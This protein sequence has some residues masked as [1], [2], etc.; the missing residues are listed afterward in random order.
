MIVYTI[1]FHA[2]GITRPYFFSCTVTR[3]MNAFAVTP[4]ST[5]NQ[6]RTYNLL[7]VRN[8]KRKEGVGGLPLVTSALS[9]SQVYRTLPFPSSTSITFFTFSFSITHPHTFLSQTPS[10]LH[11][12]IHHSRR[13][14]SLPRRPGHGLRRPH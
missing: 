12:E 11:N 14:S 9:L 13:R 3:V 5:Y 6:Q 4:N 10:T 7:V 8:Q 1:A 2:L